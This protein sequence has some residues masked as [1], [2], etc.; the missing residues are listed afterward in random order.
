MANT[1]S[2]LLQPVGNAPWAVS[3]DTFSRILADP[4]PSQRL[5]AA[6]WWRN[7]SD[8]PIKRAP[9]L[10][11]RPCWVRQ[12]PRLVGLSI[13]LL[14]PLA[15]PA[16]TVNHWKAID[17]LRQKLVT[18]GV[19]VVQQDCGQRGLQGLYH[20]ASDTIVICRTHADPLAVWNTLA[21]EATHR[22]QVCR[23][24]PITDPRHHN[25]MASALARWAPIEWHSLQNYPARERLGELEARYTARLPPEQVLQ[26]FER[27]CGQRPSQGLTFLPPS[28]P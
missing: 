23:G 24:G 28:T 17:R 18:H 9:P 21:H 27:Y 2:G 22:M 15:A 12:R 10:T 5:L 1:G 14:V 7:A 3:P 8:P 26:L 13:I 6:A 4:R 11:A 20:Q 19:S 16:A 25:A